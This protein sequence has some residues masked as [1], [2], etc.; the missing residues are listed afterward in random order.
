[1]TVTD[2]DSSGSSLRTAAA[3]GAPVTAEDLTPGTLI[4]VPAGEA[5]RQRPFCLRIT[6]ETEVSL[7]TGAVTVH[8]NL[9]GAAGTTT[10]G[11]PLPRTI[12]IQLRRL[13]ILQRPDPSA[14]PAYLDV[15]P[16]RTQIAVMHIPPGIPVRLRYWDTG[17][18]SWAVREM[19]DLDHPMIMLTPGDYQRIG[20]LF[21]HTRY[22]DLR[23]IE[24]RGRAGNQDMWRAAA[25]SVQDGG[26]VY[27]QLEQA[28][29][30]RRPAWIATE[31]I[32]G[33]ALPAPRPGRQG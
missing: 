20:W 9:L 11:Q 15:Q 10:R 32:D 25:R 21:W 29:G 1:M 27:L 31:M 26:V 2:R 3:A 5:G 6:Q 12:V 28:P 7:A 8:G 19:R 24:Q 33:P 23:R 4:A 17:R 22:S 13:T 16:S 18:G 30:G 14:E